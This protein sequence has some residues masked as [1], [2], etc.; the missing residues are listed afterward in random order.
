MH[1]PVLGQ[2]FLR[3]PKVVE[4]IL[5]A[6]ELKPTDTALEIGPGKGVLTEPLISRVKNLVAVEL[7]RDLA[8]KLQERFGNQP[9]V[10]I[11]QEDFLKTDLDQLFSEASPPAPLPVGEGSKRLPFPPPPGE[12]GPP[13]AVG[14]AIKILG[15]LPYSITSP[16]FEKILAW[17]RWRTGVFL[18]QREVGERIRSAPGSK[19]FGVL[20]LA[21]QLFAE[22][23]MI[24]L[25]KPG[26]F[27]P[28]PEVMSMVIRLRRRAALPIP[29]TDVPA[30]FDLAHAAFSHRRKTL[31]NT[32][33]LFA[34]VPKKKVDA[35][36]VSQRVAPSARAE[37]LGLEEYAR[38]AHPWAIFRR[39]IDLT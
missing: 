20:S 13:K 10:K 28:P 8:P 2:H 12:G 37:S 18:I 24:M 38:L 33:S 19:V 4:T 11:V 7:D 14:E 31:V 32:L 23:E 22:T 39:E 1:R 9:H 6:A 34:D 3:D 35:W 27:V 17:P 21:V 16:I 26:A 36:L 29:E 25:V 15:N 5:Q 30:F